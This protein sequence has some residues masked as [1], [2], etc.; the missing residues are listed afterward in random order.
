MVF[1]FWWTFPFDGDNTNIR[2]SL[3]SICKAPAS[4]KPSLIHEV[5]YSEQNK[6]KQSR[7]NFSTSLLKSGRGLS[8]KNKEQ[9]LQTRYGL[10]IRPHRIPRRL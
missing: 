7:D 4:A 9:K 3:Y 5:I 1:V 6:K 10:V 2:C 8:G